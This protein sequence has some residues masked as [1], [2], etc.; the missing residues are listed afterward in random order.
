MCHDVPRPTTTPVSGGGY[1]NGTGE[2]N[3]AEN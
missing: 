3:S 1:G 2:G